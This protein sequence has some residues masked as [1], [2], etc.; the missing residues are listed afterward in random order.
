MSNNLKHVYDNSNKVTDLSLSI[1][2]RQTFNG[3]YWEITRLAKKSYKYVGVDMETAYACASAKRAQYTRAFSRLNS[4]TVTGWQPLPSVVA[5]IECPSDI[6]AQHG[7]GDVW[8]VSISVNEED[9]VPSAN[10]VNN[11]ASL[12]PA[13]NGRNYD[14]DSSASVLTLNS[15]TRTIEGVGDAAIGKLTVSLSTS[16]PEIK[17][18]DVVVQYKTAESAVNW[19]SAGLA[20]KESVVPAEGD[21]I[22]RLYWGGCESNSITVS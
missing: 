2:Y 14:E 9:V 19:T 16:N 3:Q 18:G 10:A 11:P 22:V 15:A 7:E 21:L 12:F 4:S 13:A 5:A 20:D 17:A 6:A 8:S 1:N